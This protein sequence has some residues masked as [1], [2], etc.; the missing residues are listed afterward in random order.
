ME[1]TTKKFPWFVCLIY[2]TDE[3]C[4]FLHVSQTPLT[5]VATCNRAIRHADSFIDQMDYGIRDTANKSVF[6]ENTD[7]NMIYKE[8]DV[9]INQGIAATLAAAKAWWLRDRR[10]L[11]NEE[12]EL[13]SNS[14]FSDAKRVASVC[15]SLVQS[16]KKPNSNIGAAESSFAFV[17][18]EFASF[19]IDEWNDRYAVS[20]GLP[21]LSS[22]NASIAEI[23]RAIEVSFFSYAQH[24]SK[25][26]A[27]ETSSGLRYKLVLLNGPFIEKSD[28]VQHAQNWNAAGKT[29]HTGKK[30]A[31]ENVCSSYSTQRIISPR[32]K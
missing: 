11:C 19:Q 32:V 17:P 18:Q 22:T 7:E 16:Q 26:S 1:S 24:D 27:K 31:K 14:V 12:N 21:I 9:V 23:D 4:P 28:A 29:I 8:S 6:G 10:I 2:D 13:I 5:F 15:K 3:Q 25:T 30:L 20:G